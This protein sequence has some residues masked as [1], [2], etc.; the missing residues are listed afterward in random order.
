MSHTFT[1]GYALLVGVDENHVSGYALPDVAKDIQAVAKVLV[2]PQRCAYPKDNVKT[3]TGQEATRQ[4]I[5]DGLEWLQE[6]I[7]A[8]SSDN[9]TAIVYYTGHGW[10][11]TSAGSSEFY[12]VPYDIREGQI[13]SRA[14]RAMDFAEAVGE[15]K[16]RRL[17]VV[18]DCCHA[19]GMGVKGL[20]LPPGYVEAAIAP[21]LLMEGEQAAVGPEAKGAKGLET[22]ALGTGRAVL[23]S[24]TGEQSSYMRRDGKMSIFTYHLIEAL[25]G[26]AQPQ[27][28]ATEVL[29][30][31]VMGHVWR[32]VPESAKSL[33]MEQV[34][35]FQVSGNFPIALLLGGKGLSKGQP[36]PDPLEP[37]AGERKVRGEQHIQIATGSYIA[38]ASGGSTATVS[39]NQPKE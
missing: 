14:L 5:L 4:G 33:G 15:L 8:D 22:L 16:P 7:Q 20:P 11:N 6:R 9:T 25:T 34:P 10:H 36:A 19:G 23:S 31:D 27:E 21:S 13:R 28:G 35:D 3:L 39:V 18:L 32:R 1:H 30:S 12:F 24:S 29:V 17:L 26:H 2:H 37:L 38:Q